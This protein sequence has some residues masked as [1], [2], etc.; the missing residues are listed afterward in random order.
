MTKRIKYLGGIFFSLLLIIV[1]INF[2]NLKGDVKFPFRFYFIFFLLFVAIL[3]STF[4]IY[5]LRYLTL[6][7]SVAFI[8]FYLGSCSCT[9]GSFESI[10]MYIGLSK[11]AKIGIG[12]FKTTLIFIVVYYFGNLYCG[13]VCHKGAIQEFLYR[14]SFS[15]RVPKK[16]DYYL[17]KLRYVFLGLIIYY[18]LINGKRIFNKIDPFKVLFNLDGVLIVVIILGITLVSSVF[19]YRPFCRYICPFGAILGLVNKIGM[20]KISLKKPEKCIH[21]NICERRCPMQA[22]EMKDMPALN[23]EFCFSCY[24]CERSCPYKCIECN[25]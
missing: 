9:T 14:E 16:L 6:L 1:S 3:G 11:Y 25:H 19:I 7:S 18:P 5:W 17:K 20:M 23:K 2:L 24:E 21:K 22:L 13:W 4:K 8:G 15:I 12:L 10:F